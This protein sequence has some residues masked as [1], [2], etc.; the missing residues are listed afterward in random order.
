MPIKWIFHSFFMSYSILLPRM[1]TLNNK[2]L[3]PARHVYVPA[4]DS[5]AEC[6]ARFLLVP[7]ACVETVWLGCISVPSL[8]HWTTPSSLDTSHERTS[9]SCSTTLLKSSSSA[10]SA[11]VTGGAAENS[12]QKCQMLLKVALIVYADACR[13]SKVT[14]QT[15]WS[16][17]L[18]SRKTE[19]IMIHGC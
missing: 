15:R 8:Y 16:E 18:L 1:L 9:C 11:N 4:S 2:M 17:T 10:I 13:S 19:F 7:S 14:S 6:I 3:S 12:T 5:W